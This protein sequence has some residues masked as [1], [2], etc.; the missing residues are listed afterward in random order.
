MLRNG[1]GSRGQSRS[2]AL[3]GTGNNDDSRSNAL[4]GKGGRGLVTMMAAV[5]V[6]GIPLAASAGGNGSKPDPNQETYVSPGMLGKADKHPNKTIHV[7]IT[8]NAGSLPK[9][10][11]LTKALGHLDR[12]L[13]LVDGIAIDL[14]AK[15]LD[16]LA[17]IPGLTITPDAP[18]HPTGF[19]SK[20]LWVPNTGID[21]LWNAKLSA[22]VDDTRTQS[23][24][25]A[26]T[27]AIVDSGV[28]TSKVTDFGGRVVQQVNLCSLPNNS[29]G[30]GRG[31]GTFVA[32]IAA[33]QAPNYAG[34]SPRSNIVSVDVMDDTGTARTSDVIAGAQWILANKDKYNIKVANF[35]LHASNSSSFTRDPLDK[36][37]E[38]LWFAGVTV[39]AAAGNYGNAAGPS[40]VKYAP[41]N[42]PFVITVG[43]ADMDG[44]PNPRNDTAP[45][46]SA[47]GYTN[48]GFA[49]PEI[50]AD[51]RYMVGP[52][53]MT[54]TL[55]SQKADHIV[56][57]GYIQLSG[58]SF[59][60]P[61]VSGIAAQIIA[62][63]PT[64]GPDQVKGAL[65]KT[66]RPT[67]MAVPGSLGLGEVNAVR[68]VTANKVPN[69]NAALEQFVNADS[70]GS[71]AFD[72]V[73][74]S[75]TAKAN[76]SWDAVSWG[77]VSWGD[78]ALAAVA[79]SDVAW[80]DVSWADSL[81]TADVSWADIS[82][83]DS[84]YEDAAEGDGTGPPSDYIADPSDLAQAAADPALQLPADLV[85]PDPTAT[86]TAAATAPAATAADPTTIAPDPTATASAPA[87]STLP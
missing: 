53:P 51:G 43:A 77:D 63:N 4:W 20:Q 21:K 45:S 44:D 27:I 68:A 41:G 10:K 37:V 50:A 2:S 18:A 57:P 42:D 58:T 38:Q 78:S 30:D 36:A 11:I 12:Q 46:W 3:W 82:W 19:T 71:M 13:N 87:T 67:P 64:W 34:A 76:V 54:S 81:A 22:N 85:A 73:S 65:M 56:S 61:I 70:S 40:G 60:A 17:T 79:W 23:D 16:D 5:L 84:S 35:S 29:S 75:D 69:P 86:A 14:P 1:G 25:T 83:S 80:S 33:G 48:D 6:L 49:K 47:Y 24:I 72:A 7:I 28:D 15:Q 9:S 32:G 39:V 74:W 59:A 52:V 31:H 8:A 55:A 62:R 26:P 66:A